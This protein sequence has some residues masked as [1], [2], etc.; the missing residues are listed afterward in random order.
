M[1]R[2]ACGAKRSLIPGLVHP[3]PRD[4]DDCFWVKEAWLWYASRILSS[5]HLSKIVELGLKKGIDKAKLKLDL[6]MHPLQVSLAVSFDTG[7]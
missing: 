3:V 5:V 1:K 4:G 6:C 2:L 7:E